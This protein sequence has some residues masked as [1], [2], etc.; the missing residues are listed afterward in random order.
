[1]STNNENTAKKS[2]TKKK[3]ALMAAAGLLV[4]GIAG[5]GAVTTLTA[6]LGG[7]EFSAKIDSETTPEG[8][9]IT[10]TGDPLVHEFDIATFNDSVE[11]TWSIN[12]VGTVPA[13]Y[14]GVLNA[15]GEVPASLAEQLRV[16][17]GI[18]G[19]AAG[20]TRWL[21]AGTLA[22][23]NSFAD[24]LRLAGAFDASLDATQ[25]QTVLVRVT[26]LDPTQLQGED[27]DTL[28]VHASFDVSYYADEQPTS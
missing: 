1:M 5:A 23:P 8:A 24:T 25:T 27:G 7:N 28:T 9:L 6:S 22:A 17:Y 19:E 10:V 26:L 21:E 3:L 12:N 18:P 13:I 16:E 20:E 2:G 14:D 15:T 11:G 4:A